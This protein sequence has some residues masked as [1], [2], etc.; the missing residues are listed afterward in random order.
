MKLIYFSLLLLSIFLFPTL[1]VI[2]IDGIDLNEL[3][4]K[5]E[6]LSSPSSD[7][8]SIEILVL[9]GATIIDGTG[10]TPKADTDIIIS[11]NK[12]VAVTNQS[13][14]IDNLYSNNFNR[15]QV[16]ENNLNLTGKYVIPGL[17]DMHAHVAG[18]LK[19]SYNQA[20][21]KKMLQMLLENGITTIRNPGGPTNE[22][23]SLRHD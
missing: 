11:G 20:T 19:D 6:S 15:M 9:H 3:G 21:S 22:S 16:R 2:P 7:N 4:Q 23:I 18:V 12:I 5:K 14:Y 1:N 17:F 10:S 13:G 8:A